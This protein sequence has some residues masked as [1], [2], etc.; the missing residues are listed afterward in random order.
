MREAFILMLPKLGKDPWNWV[1]SGHSSNL[2]S[3]FNIEMLNVDVKLLAKVLAL[4]LG[5]VIVHLVQ[6]DQ[7]GFVPRRGSSYKLAAIV[8]CD[9]RDPDIHLWGSLSDIGHREGFQHTVL[10]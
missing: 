4:W 2:T 7:C 8:T 3:T 6:E 5:W 10:A 1:Q 9:A